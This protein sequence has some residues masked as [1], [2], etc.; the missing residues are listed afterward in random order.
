MKSDGNYRPTRYKRLAA[1]LAL[2]AVVFLQIQTASHA[3]LEHA[4]HG[5]HAE[6][7][8][9]CLKI[10]KSGSVPLAIAAATAVEHAS[11]PPVYEPALVFATRT[12]NPHSARGPPIA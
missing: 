11:N 6:I 10:D 7:C 1:W 8:E 5:S 3:Q 2:C 4:S 12:K 9:V